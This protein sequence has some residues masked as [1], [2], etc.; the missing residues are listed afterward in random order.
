MFSTRFR[1]LFLQGELPLIKKSIK[2]YWK[3]S[4]SASFMGSGNLASIDLQYSSASVFSAFVR[5]AATLIRRFDN[6]KE[7]HGSL[8][9]LPE[10]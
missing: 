2:T 1:V 4:F 7:D 8:I 10:I 9:K 5:T 3:K 6:M